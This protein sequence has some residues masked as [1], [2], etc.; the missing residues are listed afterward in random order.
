VIA[1]ERHAY[2]WDF[3]QAT[4]ALQPKL[5]GQSSRVSPRRRSRGAPSNRP[6]QR[7]NGSVASLP[8]PF[9]AERQYR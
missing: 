4:P 9:A 1:S 5:H 2:G 3:C 6:L 8:L 7:T